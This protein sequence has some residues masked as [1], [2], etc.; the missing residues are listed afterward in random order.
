MYS[1]REKR[2]D[3]CLILKIYRM[4]HGS[5]YKLLATQH[6]IIKKKGNELLR[7]NKFNLIY[8][9][10]TAFHVMALGPVWK[11]KFKV[12]NHLKSYI[13]NI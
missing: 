1:K 3:F 4:L 10:T 9:S 5:K 2:N 8:F 11:K 7:K 12:T 13:L 6:I